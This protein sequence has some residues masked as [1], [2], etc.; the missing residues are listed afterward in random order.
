MGDVILGLLTQV[1]VI[2]GG[3]LFMAGLYLTLNGRTPPA[4]RR[5][6]RRTGAT[7]TGTGQTDGAETGPGR[8]P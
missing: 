7:P 1:N 5:R 2:I 6:A 3:V 8:E 4:A